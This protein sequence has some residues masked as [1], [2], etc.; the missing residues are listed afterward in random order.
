MLQKQ[1]LEGQRKIQAAHEGQDT[2]HWILNK[3]VTCP[4]LSF[5]T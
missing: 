2:T 1:V 4:S 5:L 3:Q